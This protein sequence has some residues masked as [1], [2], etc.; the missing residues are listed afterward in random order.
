M[1]SNADD[2]NTYFPGTANG[3]NQ[4]FAFEDSRQNYLKMG[5]FYVNHLI[6]TND[7]RLPFAVAQD[8]N[9]NY[10]GNAANDLDSVST[11]YIGSAFAS[12][13]SA[14]GLVTYAEAKFIEAEA[15]LIL[16]QDPKPALEAAVEASVLK[17]TGSSATPAFI[18]SVTATADLATI[19][20]QKYNALFLT[21]EPYN[22][23]RRTGLPA[24]VPNSGSATQTIPVRLPTPSDERNYNPNATVISNVTTKL[25]WDAN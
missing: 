13:T 19:M 4:W 21:L 3:L 17:I 24:L 14:I 11:S 18:S 15:K 2:A 10:T 22:D 1:T 9:G 25:W 23:Y 20:Q 7:P 5:Q 6:L 8:T 16:S 12:Q